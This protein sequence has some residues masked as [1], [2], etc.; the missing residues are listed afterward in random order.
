MNR[1]YT[2]P[3][4]LL[5]EIVTFTDSFE[6]ILNIATSNKQW[7]EKILEFMKTKSFI[8]FRESMTIDININKDNND[9]FEMR[10]EFY[11]NILGIEFPKVKIITIK[12]KEIRNEELDYLLKN[13]QSI[14]ALE[15]FSLSNILT[16]SITKLCSKIIGLKLISLYRGLCKCDYTEKEKEEEF[17]CPCISYK[18]KLIVRRP[19]LNIVDS[20]LTQN[21]SILRY[22]DFYTQELK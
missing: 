9:D 7:F 18:R 12:S 11:K 20:E 4:E 22:L 2:I 10:N 13:C 16:N 6:D 3:I 21:G 14:E 5:F 17:N 8:D 15:I 19:K 1:N